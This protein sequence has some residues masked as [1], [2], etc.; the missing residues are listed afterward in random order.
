MRIKNRKLAEE[1]LRMT[2]IDQRM[3]ERFIA[4]KTKWNKRLDKKHTAKL[5]E[6]VEQY[7]WPTIS[8]VGKKAS[9]GAWL[10]AQHAV[11]DSKFQKKVLRLM[12]A[13]YRKDKKGIDLRNVAL[14]IDRIRIIH[15]RNPQLFG[16]QFRRGAD[17]RLEPFPIRN[18]KGLNMRRKK[19]GLG[20]FEKNLAEL[21][22]SYTSWAGKAKKEVE[23][24]ERRLKLKTR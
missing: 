21:N 13:A 24:M 4:G 11:H 5:K 20:K 18:K 14:L 2:M 17:G 6:I 8:L 16:T 15:E 7:G 3:R 1:I 9:H 10:L 12:K 23:K 19:Y 22:Q